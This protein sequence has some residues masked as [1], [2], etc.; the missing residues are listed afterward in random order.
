VLTRR[1]GEL[2]QGLAALRAAM[3]APGTGD[4]WQR[5]AVVVATEFGRTVEING[6]RGTD[7]GTGGAA[8]VLGG[9]VQGGR[10][11]ADWPGLAPAQRFEGRD[12]H[13]TL[14]IRSVL[15]GCWA[16]AGAGRPGAGRAGLPGQR[17]PQAHPA[18][19]GLSRPPWFRTGGR[20]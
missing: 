14:D 20:R 11:L 7:H 13:I 15:K 9:R 10:V 18:V 12:L 19:A 2:D 6:T 17:G 4:A 16:P 5:T 3:M 8:W 1:L